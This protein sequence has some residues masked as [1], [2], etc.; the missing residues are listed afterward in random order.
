MRRINSLIQARSRN[1]FSRFLI[2][3]SNFMT[4]AYNEALKMDKNK[5]IYLIM[6][7]FFVGILRSVTAVSYLYFPIIWFFELDA[8]HFGGETCFGILTMWMVVEMLFFLLYYHQYVRFNDQRPRLKHKATN[9]EERIRF[10]RKCFA[11]MSDGSADSSPEGIAA[12]LRTVMEGWFLNVPLT[13]VLYDNIQ[14]WIAFGFFGKEIEDM[15]TEEIQDDREIIRIMEI[16]YLKFKFRP[17]YNK[18]A[19]GMRLNFDPLVVTQRPFI[20]YLF[21]VV[22]NW[23]SSTVLHFLLGFSMR[24]THCKSGV[25]LYHRSVERTPR[26]EEVPEETKDTSFFE[27]MLSMYD[28]SSMYDAD[29]VDEG[30]RVEN[31]SARNKEVYPIVFIHGLGIGFAHY[32]YL[33]AGLPRDRDVYLVEMVSE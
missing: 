25:M 9:R 26:P 5:D 18:Y 17:G 10:V 22:I 11:A 29:P 8:S 32:I 15:S 24:E 12:H 28:N 30:D 33:I 21:F 31:A 1:T 14:Q 6:T 3:N 23:V 13:E 19:P 4:K 27:Y 20:F 7:E 16:D 2:D